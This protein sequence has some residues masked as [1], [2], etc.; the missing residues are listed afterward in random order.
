MRPKALPRSQKRWVRLETIL[1]PALERSFMKRRNYLIA[2]LLIIIL[3]ISSV[4]FCACDSTTQSTD[5]PLAMKDRTAIN[6]AT[7]TSVQNSGLTKYLTE[8][9]LKENPTYKLNIVAKGTGASIKSAKMGNADLIW[10]HSLS[11]ETK[12]MNGG[13]G[14]TLIGQDDPRITFMHNYFVI[15]GPKNN[16]AK[17]AATDTAAEAFAKIANTKSKFVSRGDNSGT[18][19]KEVNYWDSSLNISKTN[20]PKN[21][22]YISAG[23][24]MSS[25][26]T[27][28][29]EKG[30][31]TLT[32]KA[33]YLS[34]KNNEAGDLLSDTVVSLSSSPDTR[35]PY[36]LIAVN[37][38]AKFI[39]ENEIELKDTSSININEKAA[40]VFINWMLK[41][42]TLNLIEHYGENSYGEALFFLGTGLKL[43]S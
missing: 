5:T 35:N 32:D 3:A 13:F 28:A 39:D 17:I 34:M 31:Y 24:G 36:S 30:A 4:V 40:D 11:Q 37:K 10:V 8:Y 16:P 43:V 27:M 1:P 20:I 7:T 18:H 12:F 33:T 6:I 25:C 2:T 38:D 14:R 9:F 21:D 41:P 26:L 29:N 19:T 15:V 23:Q 42:S 22:W